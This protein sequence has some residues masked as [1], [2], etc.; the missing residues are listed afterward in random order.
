LVGSA[1]DP[2]DPLVD[3]VE[4][5]IRALGAEVVD[6]VVPGLADASVQD[7]VFVL[8]TNGSAHAVAALA[9]HLLVSLNAVAA[10]AVMVVYLSLGVALGA[11][12]VD[13]VVA[14]KAATGPDGGVPH[15]MDL[16]LSPA[17]TVG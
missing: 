4:L 3:V 6:E 16:A 9:A 10:L 5:A 15:F 7:E 12:S 8:G 11:H 1:L 14:R 13:Q 17:D 2:A